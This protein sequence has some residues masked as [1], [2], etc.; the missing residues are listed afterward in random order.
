[1]WFVKNAITRKNL[2]ALTGL[3]LCF[4]LIIHL[5]GNLQLLLPQEKAQLQYNAYSAFLSGNLLVKIIS[6]GLY[7]TIILHSF[8]AI[9]LSIKAKQVAGKTYA[10]DKR[11][12]ASTWYSRQMMLLG[13]I[14][15][16]F[17]VI[18][19]KD[20]WFPYKFGEMPVDASGHRDLYSLVVGAFQELWYVIIYAIAILALGFHLLHGFFSAH[21]SLGLYHPY[22][23]K[24]IKIF[25]I[26]FAAAMTF[27]YLIIPFYLY[28]N[29]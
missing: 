3:F 25:G 20:F 4:F 12:R 10:K 1:M 22:Y 26:F 6:Y 24:I 19:F 5:L 2:M 11:N 15:F 28:L 21:R 23:S 18:H 8:D 27:G 14:V 7:A 29:A 9:Y 16:A 13:T 17:L